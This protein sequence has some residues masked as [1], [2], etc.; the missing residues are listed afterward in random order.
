[1]DAYRTTA[2]QL[3]AW[4]RGAEQAELL[5][6]PLDLPQGQPT[7]YHA[8]YEYVRE[9]FVE[10]Y[11]ANGKKP[12]IVGFL[13]TPFMMDDSRRMAR[14]NELFDVPAMKLATDFIADRIEA[15][16]AAQ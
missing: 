2:E 16:E 11:I 5:T 6:S 10:P 13:G 15:Y 3:R 4:L 8:G 1:M 9:K 14:D 12:K 7:A